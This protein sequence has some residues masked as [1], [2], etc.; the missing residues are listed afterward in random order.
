M[1][2]CSKKAYKGKTKVQMKVEQKLSNVDKSTVV[3]S[4][5]KD[6]LATIDGSSY[7]TV[8]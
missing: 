5:N 6:G 2:L 4:C 3:Y 1:L 7:N 8:W